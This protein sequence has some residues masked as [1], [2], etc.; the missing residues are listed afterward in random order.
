MALLILITLIFLPQIHC[1]TNKEATEYLHHYKHIK[2]ANPS[3]SEFT[4]GMKDFQNYAQIP[5]TGVLDADTKEM[6]KAGRCF[7][8]NPED[9]DSENRVRRYEL[10]KYL[11]NRKKLTYNMKYPTN[12]T[13]SIIDD[14][15]KRA[16]EMWSRHSGIQ[17]VK[18]DRMTS[19]LKMDFNYIDEMSTLGYAYYPPVG[20][21]VF[22]SRRLWSNNNLPG[23]SNFYQV[24]LH[25][26]GHALGLRHSDTKAAIMFPI[27]HKYYPELHSDDITGI[28][29]LYQ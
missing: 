24:A 8:P 23:H 16:F 5:V 11:W 28:K 29:A 25:E 10:Y 2:S 14:G 12:V 6:M 26:I 18:S 20:K 22:T 13:S 15:L 7:N 3:P 17:F 4:E 9:A 19:H 21:I 27:L 1:L